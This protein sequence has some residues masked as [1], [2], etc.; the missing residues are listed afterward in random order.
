MLVKNLEF[1]VSIK[2]DVSE[3][4]RANKMCKFFAKWIFAKIKKKKNFQ[5]YQN[6][7]II[8]HSLIFIFVS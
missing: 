2:K 4:F 3:L 5:N 7:F 1:I 8:F 6:F